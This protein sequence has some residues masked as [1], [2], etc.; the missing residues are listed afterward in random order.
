MKDN[1][2]GL[3]T[4]AIVG[5]GV[6]AVIIFIGLPLLGTFLIWK[7]MGGEFYENSYCIRE[8]EMGSS[9]STE[10]QLCCEGLET[11]LVI[12]EDKMMTTDVFYCTKCGDGNCKYP[13][14]KYNC[15]EDC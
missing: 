9:Y 4:L 1:K 7:N 10:P 12:D 3:S 5:I 14:N 2:K 13:E 15:P 11:I 6:I 8:G